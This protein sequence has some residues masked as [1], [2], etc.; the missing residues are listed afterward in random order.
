MFNKIIKRGNRKGARGDNAEAAARPAAP[1]SSSGSG[2]GGAGAAAPVTVNHASRATAPSPSSPT[3]PHVAPSALATNPAGAASPPL[4]EPLPLLR[5]VAAADRPGLFLRKLRIV[6]ALF[7]LSDSLKHPR[8]KEAKRQALLEL[9]DYVQAPAQA[10]GANAPTR[11][12]DHVQEALVAAISANIFR[13]LP[14][15]LHES[16][17]AIDPGAAPDE[18]EEPYLD[19][20]W[21]HLQ[22][23][24]ELLL[25]YVVSPDTD[26]K[27]AKRYVD[28][29]FV[30]RLLD[31]FDS[32]DPRERE[33]LKTVLHRIYGKFMVHRPFIRKAI[34]NVFYRFIFE[35]QRHNGIGELLEILG[36]IINGFALPMKEEHKLFLARA[37][38]PL[39]KPKSVAI[40]H[41]QLSYCIVQFVEKDYKLADTVIRGLLKYWPVTNCQKEVLFLGELEE[42]LE[43]TQPAEFQRCMVPLFKQIGRCLNSSHF[44]VAERALFLWNNDHIVSLIAQN[45]VVIFPII[46]EALERNIQSH[47]NQAVHGLTANVRKMF[48]DMDSELFE[49]CQQQYMEKQAKAKEIQEQRESAWR[50]LEAVVAAKAAGDDMVLVN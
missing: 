18:E 43:A 4:L 34:N 49:E 12:P 45:R 15:A 29:A 1:S 40:Y 24:Y 16:A 38:I 42:V 39:H 32:E 28:H 23:V 25:R 19:P 6:A 35:T 47:W 20:S 22:L 14:P 26:T 31:L 7:D 11:L 36:S 2:G 8:E 3:S 48:L 17:A 9:V 30:L 13:P 41:Q 44:Q 33:Y 46:F 27:V 5:D 10:A 37:L 21:P 50:Q